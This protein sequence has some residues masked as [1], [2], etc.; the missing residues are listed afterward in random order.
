MRRREFI[1]GLGTAAAVRP[2]LA[3]QRA[4]PVI[5]YL[6]GRTAADSV[7]VLADFRSGLGQAG[8]VEGRNVAIEYRWLEGRYD[9]LPAMLGDLIE[10]RVAVIA[11]PN[12]TSAVLAAKAATQTIPIVFNVGSDPVVIGLVA[13]LNRPGGNLTGTAMQQIA[14]AGK[15]LELM[16]QLKPGVKSIAFLV[17]R[18][19]PGFT[20]PELRETQSAANVLGVGLDI[21]NASTIGEIDAAFTTLIERQ[22]GALVIGGDIFFLSRTEQLVELA[23]RHAVP[24]I[25]AYTEQTGA[26]GL[27][28]YGGRLAETQRIVG[29]Y[30]GRILNGEKAADLPVQQVTKVELSIN[31]MT[32]KALGLTIPETLLATADEVIQ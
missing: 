20:E 10:R 7:D 6:S 31:L 12:T 28:S 1:A 23:A 24:V 13:S 11:I 26:G 8:Y 18:A 14:V 17:N 21:L 32:A 25:Y 16:H 9:Q 3:Q 29:I 30:T 22:L 5:G 2:V 15:R 4:M 27:M 19:N